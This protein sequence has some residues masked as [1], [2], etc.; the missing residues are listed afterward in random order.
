MQGFELTSSFDSKSQNGEHQYHG[1]APNRER[2]APT[3]LVDEKHYADH[4]IHPGRLMGQPRVQPMIFRLP[5]S[6]CQREQLSTPQRAFIR[7]PT[8]ALGLQQSQRLLKTIWGDL[9]TRGGSQQKAQ[10]RLVSHLCRVFYGRPL[11]KNRPQYPRAGRALLR[12]GMPSIC[13]DMCF[14]KI[15]L[16]RYIK[17]YI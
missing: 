7:R 12:K 8:T 9:V 6:E 11:A 2:S 16:T 15:F 3:V 13:S 17:S 1:H 5:V 4:A 14:N 10:Q